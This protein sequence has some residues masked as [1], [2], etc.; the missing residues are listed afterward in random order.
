MTRKLTQSDRRILRVLQAEG[1]ISNVDLAARVG[2]SPSPC[3]RR[4]RQLEADGIVTGYAATVDPRAVGLGVEAFIQVSIERH[5]DAEARTFR[6]AVA[7]LPEVVA[8]YIMAGE[9]D[10]LLRIMVA[11]LD[12]YGRFALDR[13]M[14]IP[15]IKDV[16]SSFVLEVVKS[17]PEIPLSEV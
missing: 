13:L 4:V 10:F 17:A 11:D 7:A 1:R 5:T 12:A 2:M 8:C 15:G 14:K 6:D 3:L 16:R 9:M